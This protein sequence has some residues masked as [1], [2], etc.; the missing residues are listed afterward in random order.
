MIKVIM[1]T[2]VFNLFLPVRLKIQWLGRLAGVRE[3]CLALL[4][5]LR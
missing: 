4:W 3:T 5:M 1:I 2:T